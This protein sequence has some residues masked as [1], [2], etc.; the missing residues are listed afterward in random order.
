MTQIYEEIEKYLEWLAQEYP[1][2][3]LK[4]LDDLA[5]RYFRTTDPLHNI[6]LKKTLI[7]AVARIKL[8]GCKHDAVT[9]LMGG[10]GIGKT[11]FWQML[12]GDA[13][14]TDEFGIVGVR[15]DRISLH[16]YWCLEWENFESHYHAEDIFG[17]KKLISSTIDVWREPYSKDF[18]EYRRRSILVG[19]TNS[20][21]FFKKGIDDR[22][23]WIIPVAEHVPIEWLDGERDLIWSTAL[24][25]YEAAEAWWLTEEEALLREG[26][27]T[28]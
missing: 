6:Y 17:L 11:A 19:S 27:V 24:A 8:P 25:L 22:R 2:P 23:L 10:Q 12:F 16:R 18:K 9:V 5:T 13:W 14:F 21:E 3:N 4:L 7:A 26:K 28:T 1:N 20:N 15:Q